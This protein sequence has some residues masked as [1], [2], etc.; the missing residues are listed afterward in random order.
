M[1]QAYTEGALPDYQMS[2]MMMAICFAG[3]N[4]E[5]T[6]ALTDAMTHSGTVLD[7]YF[8]RGAGSG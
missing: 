7:L 1:I 2:A 6:A 4:A 3:M 5:E 8:G